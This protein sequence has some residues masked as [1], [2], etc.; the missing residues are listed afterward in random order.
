M[1]ISIAGVSGGRH[2]SG[3]VVVGILV[4]GA[5]VVVSRKEVWWCS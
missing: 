4:T 2:I 3:A 1:V 5:A